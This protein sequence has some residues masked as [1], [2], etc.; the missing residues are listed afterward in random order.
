[1]THASNSRMAVRSGA[2]REI[3]EVARVGVVGAG[4]TGTG[5]AEVAAG[6]GLPT[7]LVGAAVRGDAIEERGCAA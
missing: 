5:I 6:A 1:M 3:V 7:A 2:D 4:L